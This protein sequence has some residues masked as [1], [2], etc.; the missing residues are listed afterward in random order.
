MTILDDKRV[1]GAALSLAPADL[2]VDRRRL[3]AGPRASWASTQPFRVGTRAAEHPVA[4]TDHDGWRTVA[5]SY[6]IRVLCSDVV[7]STAVVL[8]VL[9]LAHGARGRRGLWPIAV[10][11]VFLAFLV[12]FGG[13][14]RRSVGDGPEEFRAVMRAGVG[15]VAAVGL[16][17]VA[18]AWDMPRELVGGTILTIVP[19][20]A[21]GRYAL[22]RNLH[23]RRARGEAM[24]RTLVV[25]DALSVHQ[26]VTDLRAAPHHGY[27]IVGLCL[28]A[29]TDK[30][31]QDAVP[32]LGALADIPQVAFDHH[33]DVVI[34]T[35]SQLAGEALRRLSWALGR[36]GAALVVA[37]GLVEVLGPRIQ[38][39]PTAGLTLLE[40]ET[41][42][43]RSRRLAK[44]ALDRT[45]GACLLA[46]AL[47]VIAGSAVAVAVTSPGVPFYRQ[48]RIG[49]DGR[50]F[51]M[52]KLRS[53]YQDADA[54]RALLLEHSDRDGLMFKMHDDPRVTPVGRVLRRYSLDE[55]PQLWN[56]LRGDMSLVGPR[57]PLPEEVDAYRDAVNRRLRVRP[58]LTGLWQVS[59]RADLSWE[60]SIRLDL[61]YVDNWSVTMDLFILWKTFR[62]VLRGAGAY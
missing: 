39:R 17:S 37:P 45:I 53:M 36:S 27:Q 19:T 62:V 54:R 58:G 11:L 47:P 46:A 15:A 52:W 29:V 28:P 16:T 4:E 6:L 21:V 7:T 35:G 34:V 8:S 22:R 1:L 25:G 9:L 61:R 31:T 50:E 59:G 42:S 38:L 14:D 48:R 32:V 20:V 56:V 26:V 33:I 12:A 41:S 18:V 30:P 57:P 60:E 24:S 2:Q 13:Y 51:T 5:R 44:A 23:R 55:L 40:V 49:I 3:A 10:A 43:P